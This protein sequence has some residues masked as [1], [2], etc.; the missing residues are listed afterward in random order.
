VTQKRALILAFLVICC[1]LLPFYRYELS[2]DAITYLS[3]ARQYKEGYFQ[4]AISDYWS[5]LFSW[6]VALLLTLRIPDIVAAKIVCVA[7][8]AAALAA[9][10]ALADLLPLSKL[11]RWAMLGAGAI[12]A[13]ACAFEVTGPDLLFAALLL[14]YFRLI[15]DQRFPDLRFAGVTCGMLGGLGYLTKGYGLAFF[16]AHFCLFSA[17]HWWAN[18]RAAHRRIALQ[19]FSGLAVFSLI[20]V[21]WMAAM[22]SKYGVWT[23]GKTGAFNYRL[24]GPESAGYPHL[25]EL[26]A[27]P[28]AHAVTA[29]QEPSSTGLRNWRIFA[30]N[31]TLKHEGKLIY[32]DTKLT[33]EYWLH[34]APVL[35]CLPLA[36]WILWRSPQGRREWLFAG[37]TIALFTAGY[38]LITMEHRYLWPTILLL[39]WMAFYTLDAARLPR[40]WQLPVALLVALSFAIQPL[41]IL[42]GHFAQGRELQMSIDNLRSSLPPGSRL[43]SCNAWAASAQLAYQLDARYFGV[44]WPTAES[45]E[46]A[47]ALNPDYVAA[48]SPAMDWQGLDQK[49]KTAD[50]QYFLIWPGCMGQ[51]PAAGP[52]PQVLR[53]PLDRA[54]VP[55]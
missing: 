2:P 21:A 44:P 4:E 47:R 37:V 40:Q 46:A 11:N 19:C 15:F 27:P 34:A 3:I 50:I 35:L 5:P 29:W 30:N 14:C 43:A 8:G 16:G 17:W 24:V 26:E 45:I 38:L 20:V 22:H 9:L 23:T 12:I 31:F 51:P 54:Q 32:R 42:R 6:L 52:G 28:S 49:L 48:A 18:G 25:R 10:A 39:L 33:L 1:L 7:S 55:K 36:F 13:A 53:V 41:R